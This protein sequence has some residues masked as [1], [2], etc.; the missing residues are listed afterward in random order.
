MKVNGI[1]PE[2]IE[3]CSKIL[4]HFIDHLRQAGLGTVSEIF[5][6]NPP[7]HPRGCVSQAWSVGEV[8]RVYYEILLAKEKEARKEESD[9]QPSTKRF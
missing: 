7:F 5:D 2:T 8:L 4:L 9:D 1:N 6:G 3:K